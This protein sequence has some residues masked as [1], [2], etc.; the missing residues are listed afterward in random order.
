MLLRYA[1]DQ[2]DS[3][4]EEKILEKHE[5]PESLSS[6]VESTR[7][8]FLLQYALEVKLGEKARL[9]TI[10]KEEEARLKKEESELKLAEQAFDNFLQENDRKAM[11]AQKKF[12][13]LCFLSKLSCYIVLLQGGAG[14]QN[15]RGEGRT[16]QDCGGGDSPAEGGYLQPEGRLQEIL[17]VRQVPGRHLPRGLEEGAGDAGSPDSDDNPTKYSGQNNKAECSHMTYD[18]QFLH[19]FV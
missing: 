2:E 3:E 10:I 19:S 12:V 5:K 9:E 4:E 13:F 6:F 8:M 1:S 16:H 14:V 15:Y 18:W 7:K 17:D 11:E